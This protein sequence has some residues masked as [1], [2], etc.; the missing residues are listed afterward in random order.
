MGR[1]G[2]GESTEPRQLPLAS[3][4]ARWLIAAAVLGSGIALLDGTVVNVAL[5]TIGRELGGG[6]TGQQW[7]LDGYLLTL[8]ALLLS[9][10]AAGDRYGRRRV[11]LAGLVVF[12]IASLGC[13]LAPTIGWLI[14]ARLVQGVGAAALVPGSLALIDAGITDAD[15]GRAVGLWAGMSGVTTALGPLIGGWL[16]DAA[17]WRW[18]FLLNLPLAVAVAWIAARHISESCDRTARGGPDIF[19]AAAVTVGLAGVIFALIETPSRGWTFV[20]ATSACMGLTALVAFPLIERRAPSPLLP[21]KLFRSR[22][23]TGANL[24]T[25][26]VYTAIGGALFLLTVQLQQSL[27]YSATAAGLATLPMTIIMMIGSPL[28]GALG[29][30]A[31][32]RLPMTVGPLVAAGGVALMARIVPGATYLAAILPAVIIFSVGLAITVAPL[33]AAVLSAVPDAYA[34]TASGVNNAVSRIA[35]LVAIA[36]L[37]VASRIDAAPGTPLGSGFS[38]AMII[39][40]VVCMVGG[41]VAW[42]T[43]RTGADVAHQLVPGINHACQ[44]PCTRRLASRAPDAG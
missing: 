9:G 32:P 2:G 11:F 36:V 40:A 43:I 39:I 22:Q 15:R 10:G 33:T 23:F 30:R 3:S 20:T 19:G 31:G 12:S 4:G 1:P 28:A 14:G 26:A 24:T 8:S 5:P 25:L 27:H 17:S 13:G 35:G 42:L 6:L 7:V 16:V 37:P 29:Q 38:L 18:V 44:D 21:P 41:S 34:G